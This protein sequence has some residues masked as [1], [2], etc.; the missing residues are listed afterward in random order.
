MHIF[1][2]RMLIIQ[3][4]DKF[5]WRIAWQMFL[6]NNFAD[7]PDLAKVK[8]SRFHLFLGNA[9]TQTAAHSEF[10]TYDLSHDDY[11]SRA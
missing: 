9:T 2:K 6:E 1:N 7:F 5:C 4:C 8:I 3:D 11:E 10:G